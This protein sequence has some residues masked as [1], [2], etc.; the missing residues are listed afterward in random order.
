[1]KNSTKTKVEIADDLNP[2]Y[3]FSGVYTDLL[4][5]VAKELCNPVQLAR[6]ELANRGLD[7]DGKWVGFKKEKESA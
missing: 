2:D 6:K 3:L 7:I 5:K 1:M 4:V